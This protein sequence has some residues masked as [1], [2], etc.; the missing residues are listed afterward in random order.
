MGYFLSS[1][2]TLS[3]P[4]G[5]SNCKSVICPSGSLRV[6]SLSNHDLRLC[7]EPPSMNSGPEPVEGS[8]TIPR[9]ART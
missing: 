7:R 6:V 3:K 2:M 9:V 1:S 4:F 8:R 5:I